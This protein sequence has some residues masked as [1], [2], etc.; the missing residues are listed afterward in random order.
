MH[1]SVL[2]V[3]A[4][5]CIS[6]QITARREARSNSGTGKA[7]FISCARTSR[8]AGLWIPGIVGRIDPPGLSAVRILLRRPVAH[9]TGTRRPAQ[10]AEAQL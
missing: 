4:S 6:H 3:L 2:L 9:P 7:G 5:M 8:L 1:L 10:H